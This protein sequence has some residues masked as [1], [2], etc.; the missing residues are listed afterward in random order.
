MRRWANADGNVR[1]YRRPHFNL[2]SKPKAPGATGYVP[3]LYANENKIDPLE[4]QALEMVFMQDVDG[5]AAEALSY[6]E[7]HREKPRDGK[8]QDAWSRFLKSLLHRSPERV[9]YLTR[10]VCE[11][12]ENTLNPELVDRYAALAGPND[13]SSFAEWLEK[14]GRIAPDLRVRLIELLIGSQLIGNVINR[15]HWRV[16]RLDKLEFGFISGDLP[17][18]ISN[19]LGHDRSFVMLPIGPTKLFIASPDPNLINAF[20]T[21]YPHALELAINDAIARQSSHIVIARDDTLRDFV[22]ERFLRGKPGKK[23]QLLD[24]MTWNSPLR[25]VRPM[26]SFM[27]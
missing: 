7:D 17:M 13:P 5:K 26:P 18:M 27:G 3:E 11:F 23:H 4:R 15:M 24:Y 19:G 25:E 2:T 21:Q 1:E 10:K 9:A 14:E 12:E 22:D 6:I 16:H 8:L 20:T